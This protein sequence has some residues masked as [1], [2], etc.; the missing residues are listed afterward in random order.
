MGSNWTLNHSLFQDPIAIST[1]QSEI[2]QYFEINSACGAPRSVVWDAF[3]AVIRGHWIAVTVAYK[4]EKQL[5]IQDLKDKIFKL[6]DRH[7]K[8]RGAMTLRK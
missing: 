4:K 6:E 7:L 2:K 5:I 8:F 1:I 3:K